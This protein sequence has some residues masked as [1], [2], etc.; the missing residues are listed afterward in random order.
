M[1]IVIPVLDGAAGIAEAVA[2]CLHQDYPGSIEVVV[3]HGTSRDD[4]AAVLAELAASDGRVKVVDNPTGTTPAGLNRAIAASSGDV[5]VR[6]DAQA[7]LPPGYVRRAVELLGATGAANVGGVQ[8]A[9]GITPVQR[10]VAMAQ[11]SRLG[12]GDARYRTG[13]RPGPVDTVYL[14]VYRREALERAGGFDESLHRNQ[15]Y[16]L[17]HRIRKAGGTVYFHPD[18]RV[19]YRPRRSLLALWKQY[20]DYGRWK[21]VVL[22]RHIG[23]LRWRQLAP[24]ALVTGLLASAVLVFTP[25]RWAALPVPAS[26]AAAVGATS[27]LH[28]IGT[29]DRAALLLP[30]ALPTMHVGWGLGLL[31]GRRTRS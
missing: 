21:R 4:T 28:L 11:T 31:V 24:P 25:W 16:E 26:Y 2:G 22:R 18:L 10:A 6:C 3:A 1:S 8:A 17:N 12:V 7:V 19:T 5:I 13:G 27:V 30:L 20:F 15:D 14:G 9:E 23:S 29:R